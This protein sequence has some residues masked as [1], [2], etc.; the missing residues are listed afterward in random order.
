M[1]LPLPF[2]P[3]RFREAP[4][5]ERGRGD[6]IEIRRAQAED[7]PAILELS[8][9]A[10]VYSMSPL[11]PSD[12]QRARQIRRQDMASLKF[13]VRDP[14]MAIFVA[15][16]PE[17]RVV[18]EVVAKLDGR[19]FLSDQPQAWI[20]ELAVHPDFWRQGIGGRLLYAV[21]CAAREAG[22]ECVGLSVTCANERANRFY[23]SLGYQDERRLLLKKLAPNLGP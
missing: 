12:P 4:E 16:T 14:Q 3:Q 7:V 20:F 17:G 18:G 13:Q 6:G 23:D 11:R 21:E 15:R 9:E 10:A 19:D 22:L 8:E 2:R 1:A 5:A